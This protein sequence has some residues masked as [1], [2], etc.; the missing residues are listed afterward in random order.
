[1]SASGRARRDL[2][3]LGL[4]L[5]LG[6]GSALAGGLQPVAAAPGY[7]YD[8]YQPGDFVAQTNLVQCVGASMQMMVNLVSV[9]NDRTA[10]TQ[11]RLWALARKLGPP[12]PPNRPPSQGASVQGWAAGL[13]QLDQGPYAVVGYPTLSDALYSAARAMRRTGRPVGLLVWGGRHAWVMSGFQA[14]ADPAGT[15][16]FRV[17]HAFI[18]DPLYPLVSTIWPR[19][20][21]P[22]SRLSVATLAQSFVP[23]RGGWSGA[24][25]GLWVIVQP[26]DVRVG[27][28]IL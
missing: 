19:S 1:M 26:V 20:P 12:R 3:V 8:L 15:D 27:A 11:H 2:R 18:L 7:E 28:G 25:R 17:T 6:L 10:A 23:R 21:A 13:N 5:V 4:A 14:T 22:D 9:H 24:L 16:E